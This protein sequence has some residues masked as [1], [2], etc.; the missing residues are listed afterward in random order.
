M[1]LLVQVRVAMARE[2]TEHRKLAAIMFADVVGFS[3]LSHR[4]EALALELLEWLRG[5]IRGILPRHQGQQIKSLGDG[6]FLEF[7]SALAAVQCALEIQQS[8]ADYNHQARLER[9]LQLR[10][11]LH[12][13]D[14]VYHQEDVLGDG[15]NIAARVE[16]LAEPGGICLTQQ[17]FDQ[18]RT[19]LGDILKLVGPV[20]L[21]NIAS[22]MVVYRVVLPGVRAAKRPLRGWRAALLLVLSV[23]VL[24]ALAARFGGKITA[25]LTGLRL[26]AERQLVILPFRNIGD[27]PTNQA[28]GDGLVETLSGKLAQMEQ[29]Q[30]SLRVVP[31][32][33][34]RKEGI[35][36][37]LEARRTF[38]ATLALTGSFQRSGDL[39]RVTFSLV[40][41]R[42]LR[43]L[44]SESRDALVNDVFALQDELANLTVGW[45]GLELPP[46]AQA[47]LRANPPRL[48]SAYELYLQG[49][50]KLA[51]YDKVENLDTA[52]WF[53]RQAVEQD[54]GYALAYAGLGETCWRK[55]QATKEPRWIEEARTNCTHALALDN[56]QAPP[57][58]TLGLVYLGTG[59]AAEAIATFKQALQRDPAY[60]GAVRCLSLAYEQAGQLREA[61]AT[62]QRAIDRSPNY[63]AGFNDLGGFYHRLGRYPEAEQCFQRVTQLTPDNY[64]GY[65]NLGGLYALMGRYDEASGQLKK[66][67]SIRPTPQAY[68]NLGTVYFFL[69]R[70]AEA[71]RTFEQAVAMGNPDHLLWGNLADAYR[72]VP[73][74]REKAIAAYQ[75]AARAAQADLAVNPKDADTRASLAVYL[76]NLSETNRALAEIRQARQ[77]APENV[78]LVFLSALVCESAGQRER[79]LQDLEACLLKG[80]SLGEIQR[81]PDLIALRR[82][83]RFAAL[84]AA[85]TASKQTN[86]N[87]H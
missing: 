46:R 42:T 5:L 10:I 80:Y 70:F 28:L 18:V 7:P 49:L 51:R 65:R 34:V 67:L 13:G 74:S 86:T 53:F 62:F 24:A 31:V 54:P 57:H 69:G 16:P 12:L 83:P 66:S 68:S 73:A 48:A 1:V 15:V 61:E 30:G 63:W 14:V 32:T 71:A 85:S 82:E 55:Y 79:A 2:E 56:R 43:H 52:L 19:R 27:N 8:L 29:F 9:K 3:A 22:P 35:A 75:E 58:V 78:N 37:A 45:L 39:V 72:W 21:R 4:D 84:M 17:V 87:Q 59:R 25:W 26:P 44:H 50:G 38:G 6:F 23:A 36:S 64:L 40:D 11:G 33:E 47:L 20:A 76:I 77:E 41:A 81:H 60:A